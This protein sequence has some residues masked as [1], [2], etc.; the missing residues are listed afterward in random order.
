M[1]NTVNLKISRWSAKGLFKTY[2]SDSDS[3]KYT[4]YDLLG[5]NFE[6]T[7]FDDG[8]DSTFETFVNCETGES[9]VEL[10]DIDYP[11]CCFYCENEIERV[12]CIMMIQKIIIN[13]LKMRK[14]QLEINKLEV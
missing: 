11:M 8:T 2:A 1:T 9:I 6:T 12:E 5:F 7:Y 3:D 14:L 10:F 4:A 13:K